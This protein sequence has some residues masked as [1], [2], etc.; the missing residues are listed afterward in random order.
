[1]Y[2]SSPRPY[3]ARLEDPWYDAT[4]HVRRVKESGQ[5]KWQGDRVFLSEAVRGELVGIAETERGDWTVRFLTVELGR[6]DRQTRR[7]TP[8]WHGRRLG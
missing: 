3:P 1:V 7:F 6:I 4:H 2:R 5:I 8:A